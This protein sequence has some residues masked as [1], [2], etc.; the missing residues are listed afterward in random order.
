MEIR[1]GSRQ[2]IRGKRM[3]EGQEKQEIALSPAAPPVNSSLVFLPEQAKALENNHLFGSR[4]SFHAANQR[5]KSVV[6][7]LTKKPDLG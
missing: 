4:N 5:A 1:R 3:M 2:H 7:V 6:S